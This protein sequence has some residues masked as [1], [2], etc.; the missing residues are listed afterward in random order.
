MKLFQKNLRNWFVI[1][2]EPFLLLPKTVFHIYNQD[3]RI[4]GRL[5]SNNRI[6]FNGKKGNDERIHYFIV[7]PKIARFVITNML[8]ITK[9]NWVA[10]SM[11]KCAHSRRVLDVIETTF[12][13]KILY[14][15]NIHQDRIIFN[16]GDVLVVILSLNYKRIYVINWWQGIHEKYQSSNNR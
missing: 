3:P 14:M 9:V 4:G 2:V 5:K 1:R 12:M 7:Y 13:L 16:K 10:S 11:E 8:L 6:F 15:S